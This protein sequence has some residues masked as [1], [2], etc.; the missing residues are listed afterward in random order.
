[1]VQPDRTDRLD[2][3]AGHPDDASV[4]RNNGFGSIGRHPWRALLTAGALFAQTPAPITTTGSVHG[5][6]VG[7]HGEPMVNA[8]LW[9]TE[10]PD[11]DRVVQRA[12]SD[13]EGVFLF[14]RVPRHRRWFVFAECP[15]W[16]TPR[17]EFELSPATPMPTLQLRANDAVTLRGRALDSNRQPVDGASVVAVRDLQRPSAAIRPP[18]ASTGADGRFELRGVPLGACVVRA[19]APGFRVREFWLLVNGDAE[20]ELPPLPDR[21]EMELQVRVAD[22]PAE[23]SQWP[24]VSLRA[25]RGESPIVMPSCL[26]QPLALEASGEL[27]VRGLPRARWFVQLHADG[28]PRRGGVLTGVA[29]RFEA[30]LSMRPPEPVLIHG[31]LVNLDGQAIAGAVL[32]ATAEH[33]PAATRWQRDPM[34]TSTT[35]DTEGEFT[36]G[37]A[38]ADPHLSRLWLAEE[39][40][41]LTPRSSHGLR[42]QDRGSFV[43]QLRAGVQL[44]AVPASSLRARVLESHGQPVRFARAELLELAESTT[45]FWHSV[46]HAATDADGE[47]RFDRLADT[48][49]PVRIAVHGTESGGVSEPIELV[50]GK[51]GV[52]TVPMQPTGFVRGSVVG[53]KA[54]PYAGITVQLWRTRIGKDHCQLEPLFAETDR[55]GKFTFLGVP[56][57]EYQL[58]IEEMQLAKLVKADPAPFVVTSGTEQRLPPIVIR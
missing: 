3:S 7:P 27:C 54:Q 52:V 26:E 14:H 4:Q 57:G 6:V 10:D 30:G 5:R 56:A 12:R 17:A 28:A 40:L 45:G 41:V 23:R 44:V 32:F 31:T 34:V 18:R 25:L 35:T 48:E 51:E 50:P 8:A 58:R 2:G 39:S 43:A 36:I 19:A 20:I 47:L 24:T 16:T 15:G 46:A 49:H 9:L 42:L 21:G 13:G 37:V 33:G 55:A 11:G 38:A 53:G 22:L 1:M 29:P